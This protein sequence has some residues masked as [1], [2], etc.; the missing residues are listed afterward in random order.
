MADEKLYRRPG[1]MIIPMNE[2]MSALEDLLHDLEDLIE[3]SEKNSKKKPF[4]SILKKLKYS[5]WLSRACYEHCYEMA[6]FNY[7][8]HTR[9]RP[10][11]GKDFGS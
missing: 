11:Y 7:L 10:A 2:G 1:G 8:D 9:K 5:S 6:K 4:T 3:V